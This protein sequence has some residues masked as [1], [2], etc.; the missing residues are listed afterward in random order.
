MLPIGDKS[1]VDHYEHRKE[2][3]GPVVVYWITVRYWTTVRLD[4]CLHRCLNMD[5]KT[6]M[7]P[8]EICGL[9]LYIG[10]G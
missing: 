5:N 7:H 1:S 8:F 4:F 6:C 2:M 3:P 9:A 10:H